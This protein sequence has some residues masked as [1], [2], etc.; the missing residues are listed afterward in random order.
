[1]LV[2]SHCHLDRIDLS[3]YNGDLGAAIAAAEERGVSRMLCIGIDLN[4]AGRVVEIAQQFDNI[5][6]SVGIH[7]L[8][9]SDEVCGVSTLLELAAQNKVVAIGETGLDYYYS[10]DN[11][12][13]QQESFA[14][15]LQASAQ[16]GKPVIVHTREAREDT[17]ALIRE[18]G[19]PATAGVLHCFTESWEM[20]SAAME[21]GY[22]VSFSGI[23]TFKN[24]QELRDVVKKM[25][26]DRLLVE[27]DSPYLAPVPFRGKKN[28]PKYV[29]EVAACVAEIKGLTLEEVAE[30]TTANFNQLFAL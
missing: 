28:E 12:S 24:A 3:P 20:A 26:M 9:I 18:H 27:T 30:R 23:I 8:D 2:D 22:Y 7:P 10:S 17:L 6:A 25:P 14:H 16:C 19:D 4:N 13:A 11:K 15:H 1:M 21:M 5:Y 29:C